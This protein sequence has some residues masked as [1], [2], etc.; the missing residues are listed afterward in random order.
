MK[1]RIDDFF[2][3]LKNSDV[4][5]R[6]VEVEIPDDFDNRDE[7][8]AERNQELFEEDEEITNQKLVYAINGFEQSI[9]LEN[10]LNKCF[11]RFKTDLL[12]FVGDSANLPLIAEFESQIHEIMSS[13]ES[14][15]KQTSALNNFELNSLLSK[16]INYAKKLILF[17]NEVRI[18]TMSAK[19]F[20]DIKDKE[21]LSTAEAA[22]FL[23]LKEDYLRKLTSKRLIPHSKPGG[24]NLYFNKAELEEWIANASIVSQDEI[25]T[26]ANTFLYTGRKNRNQ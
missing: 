16:K 3:L 5:T 14:L 15:K 2:E 17:L 24:K 21:I 11:N 6:Y 8:I 10:Y 23:N 25:D 13:L 4:S 22:I 9:D 19:T 26:E 7:L 12:A 20:N 18:K 1:D